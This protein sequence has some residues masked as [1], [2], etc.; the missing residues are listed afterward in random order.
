MAERYL[1]VQPTPAGQLGQ[2][3]YL[4]AL[5]DRRG[6]RPDQIGIPYDDDVWAEIFEAIG[7]AALSPRP[8]DEG[9]A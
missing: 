9:A 2:R 5:D 7:K 3:I 1:D 4:E 8:A 6:F